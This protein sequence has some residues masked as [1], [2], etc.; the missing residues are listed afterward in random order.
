MPGPYIPDPTPSWL[1][2]LKP[3]NASVLDPTWF[4]V[5]RKIAD[6]TGI[7]DPKSAALALMAPMEIPANRVAGLVGKKAAENAAEDIYRGTHT[8]PKTDDAPLHDLTGGGTIYPDDVYSPRAAQLYGHFG[9]GD[10]IDRRSFRIAHE[11]K[12]KPDA[13]VWI[14]RAVPDDPKITA[15]NAGDWVTINPDYAA[16]HGEILGNY[17]ILKK[18]VKAKDIFTNGD[19]IHEWGYHPSNR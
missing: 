3:E 18:M 10:P 14:Y 15:I 9:G 6:I 17:K 7:L 4:K 8:A 11:L 12:G 5:A 2:P 16:Q 1:R 13:D 19:S